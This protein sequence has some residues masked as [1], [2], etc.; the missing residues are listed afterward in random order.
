MHYCP[1]C[2]KEVNEKAYVCLNCGIKLKEENSDDSGSVGYAILG[3]FI[4]IA[5]LILYIA[6]KDTKPKS[7]KMAGKGALISVIVGTVLSILLFALFAGLM[8]NT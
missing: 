6:L 3:Y 7:A 4:P 1:N 2:G 5:G 8:V